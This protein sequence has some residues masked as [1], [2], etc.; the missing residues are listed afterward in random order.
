MLRKGNSFNLEKLLSLDV[1]FSNIIIAIDFSNIKYFWLVERD[2]R[3]SVSIPGGF[4]SK[5]SRN[6]TSSGHFLILEYAYSIPVGKA[7]YGGCTL[8]ELEVRSAEIREASINSMANWWQII[9]N[10][11]QFINRLACLKIGESWLEK[12]IWLSPD[13]YHQ[14]VIRYRIKDPL[15]GDGSTRKGVKLANN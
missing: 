6:L 8:Q 2:E 13:N 12:S 9:T 14:K 5:I 11:S 1:D 7:N 4:H 3:L 15:V 10:L